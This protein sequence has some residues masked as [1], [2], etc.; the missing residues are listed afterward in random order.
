MALH[1]SNFAHWI[2]FTFASACIR[3]SGIVFGIESQPYFCTLALLHARISRFSFTFL[4]VFDCRYH[5]WHFNIQ[6]IALSGHIEL[7]SISVGFDFNFVTTIDNRISETLKIQN[8]DR[9]LTF[10]GSYPIFRVIFDRCWHKMAGAKNSNSNAAK[11]EIGSTS[12]QKFGE[13]EYEVGCPSPR[14]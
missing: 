7:F 10:T 3:I 9:S 12:L 2:L 1:Q 6:N 5:H 8:S 4:V 11:C 14:I 13:S